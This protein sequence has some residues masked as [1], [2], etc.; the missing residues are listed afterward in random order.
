M[1]EY[2]TDDTTNSERRLYL[3]IVVGAH[4]QAELE[5]RALGETVRELI[6]DRFVEVYVK[7]SVEVCESRDPKGL[8]KKARAGEIADFTG[9]S[10]P[11]EEP[12]N[13]EITVDTGE[14]SLE[15]SVATVVDY[16]KTNGIV[17]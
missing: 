9:I 11:Y 8:Y 13:P 15:D 16:L 4:L 7:A 12:E 1:K 2:G 6:G 14:L 3:P 17:G 10:S 5:D